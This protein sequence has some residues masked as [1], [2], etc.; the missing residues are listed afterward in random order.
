[1]KPARVR[2]Q[3]ELATALFMMLAPGSAQADGG[4]I[5]LHETQGPFSVTVFVSP[6]TVS[7]R[8]VDVSVLVQWTNTGEVVLDAD[9]RVAADRPSGSV[10]A[11]AEPLCG[12]SPT[13]AAAFEQPEMNRYPMT[14]RATREQASNKLLY[15]TAV[16]LDA[17]GDWRLS[18]EVLRGS[19][20][21]QFDCLLR[22]AGTSAK[23]RKL[24]PYLAFP[25][26]AILAFA[27]NQ[28]LRRHGLEHGVDAQSALTVSHAK[29]A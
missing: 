15:A 4:V 9:V 6:E 16:P 19:D 25:P 23:P 26:I 21:A 27:I 13:A 28:R 18:I 10:M 5:Q 1:M 11:R 17:P 29:R 2:I 3:A 14:K 8:P 22:V 24:W 12:P 7:G 20:R